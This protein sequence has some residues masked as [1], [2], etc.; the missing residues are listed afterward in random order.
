VAPE[1]N[2]PGTSAITKY[3]MSS[4]YYYII[5]HFIQINNIYI[6]NNIFA[7]HPRILRVESGRISA[8]GTPDPD[9]SGRTRPAVTRG[10][11]RLVRSPICTAF[12]RARNTECVLIIS[13]STCIF[14]LNSCNIQR[15]ILCATPFLL[16]CLSSHD[17][18]W[19]A[20]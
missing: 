16:Q 1:N 7:G 15:I 10:S 6:Y 2:L 20:L 13:Q 9:P 18:H 5:I 3:M 17:Y 8:P 19:F 14:K 11:I 4:Q 12:W